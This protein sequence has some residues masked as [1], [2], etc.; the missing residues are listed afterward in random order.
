MRL[1]ESSHRPR[2]V[3]VATGD[4]RHNSN[5]SLSPRAFS[6]GGPGIPLTLVARLAS[7]EGVA[8][9]GHRS[10]R[11]YPMIELLC[12]RADFKPSGFMNN[13]NGGDPG[14][15]NGTV[16]FMHIGGDSG[17]LGARKTFRD[18]SLR[19]VRFVSPQEHWKTNFPAR[20][21]ETGLQHPWKLRWVAN[22]SGL[23][24]L[25][26]AAFGE[27]LTEHPGPMYPL[28]DQDFERPFIVLGGL[29]AS[30]L[31]IT[32]IPCNTGLVNTDPTNN[33][34]EIVLTGLDFDTAGIFY[35]L[36]ANGRFNL[37]HWSMAM[38]PATHCQRT[39]SIR[40]PPR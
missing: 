20:N 39:A 23:P 4:S 16:V 18:G 10:W 11:S 38:P 6:V 32:N 27:T 35:S 37:G 5:I 22:T 33:I 12:T 31:Q 3:H 1:A 29:L 7:A 21:P 28:K 24:A 26:P 25:T 8:A 36:D 34:G 17:N 13:Q 19:K 40:S 2:V 9:L 14:F 15:K 30:S